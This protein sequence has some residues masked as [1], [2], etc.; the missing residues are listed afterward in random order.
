M[1]M[2][3]RSR[4]CSVED[5]L[6]LRVLMLDAS[7]CSRRTLAAAMEVE[8]AD[9]V[10]DVDLERRVRA[11]AAPLHPVDRDRRMEERVDRESK[12]L[13]DRGLLGGGEAQHR[14]AEG[15]VGGLEDD[16]AG[17]GRRCRG[18]LRG[19]AGQA[20]RREREGRREE[21]QPLEDLLHLV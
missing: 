11:D 19:A 3:G 5:P 13:A 10:R 14:A 15:L 9:E 4:M 16:P 21:G 17:M 20:P 2:P 1:Y 6:M 7:L 8:V 18:G 12:P